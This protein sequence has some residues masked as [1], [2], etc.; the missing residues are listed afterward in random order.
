MLRLR[1]AQASQAIAR[2]LRMMYG[3][4]FR[5]QTFYFMFYNSVRKGFEPSVQRIAHTRS[6]RAP[7][8]TRTPHQRRSIDA[9]ISRLSDHEVLL[10]NT[11][12]HKYGC[13]DDLQGIV[14]QKG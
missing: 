8:T 2:L 4:C 14:I 11:V 13:E 3:F 5:L 9:H 7:S 10:D 12:Q 6:R 1:S